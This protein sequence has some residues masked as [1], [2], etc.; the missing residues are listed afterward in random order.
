M[1]LKKRIA[2]ELEG[3]KIP[4]D[5]E[6]VKKHLVY[7]YHELGLRTSQIGERYGVGA[8]TVRALLRAMKVKMKASGGGKDFMEQLKSHGYVDRNDFFGRNAN[9]AKTTMADELEVSYSSLCTHYEIWKDSF[10]KKG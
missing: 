3:K 10:I 1:T 2:E 5:D 8:A 6:A 4:Y 9:Q 7:L